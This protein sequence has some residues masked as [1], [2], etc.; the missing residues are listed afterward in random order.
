MV[1]LEGDLLRVGVTG[2]DIFGLRL[3]VTSWRGVEALLSM[4]LILDRLIRL[5]LSSGIECCCV[6]VSLVGRMRFAHSDGRLGS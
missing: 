2:I 5:P 1:F 6:R 3:G 4:I